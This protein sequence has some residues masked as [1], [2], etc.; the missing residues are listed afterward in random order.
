MLASLWQWFLVSANEMFLVGG[1]VGFGLGLVIGARVRSIREAKVKSIASKGDKAFLK[2]IRYIL[3]N[4]HDHAIEEFTKSVQVDSDTIET[5]V[6]LGNLYRSKGDI[7]RAIRIRQSI[8]LRRN[9]DEK[10]RV[11][12]LFDLG[13]DYRKGGFL[14]RALETFLRV[15]QADTSNVKT[16]KEIEKIYEELKDWENAFRTR[17]KIAKL[18]K[19]DHQNILAHQ[20]VEVGKILQD[21]GDLTKAKSFYNKAISAHTG[22]VD[23]YLH[24]GDLYFGRQEYRKAISTWKKV[25]GVSPRFTFLAYSRLEGAYSRMKNLK[26]VGDFLK[27]CAKSNSDAFTHVALAR[28]MYNENDVDGALGE[29]AT[30]LKI[31]P[32]FWGARRFKGEMLLALSK[33]KDALVEYAEII[34]H[35]NLP[36]L[37]FQCSQCGFQPSELQWQCPQCKNWD[38]IDLVASSGFMFEAR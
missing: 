3:T 33:E 29:I 13:L 7:E 38:S 32:S 15:A 5:Y 14:N 37:R 24:L 27:E 16:L 26:P 35:V 25:A 34:E 19:G 2:G 6:A 10:I 18:E 28:Y 17:Q 30:A 1:I 8:I 9:I 21:K 4:D 11:E 36:Y 31:A 12:A 23:A 22:C 20:L